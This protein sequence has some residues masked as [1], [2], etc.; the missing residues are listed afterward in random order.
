MKSNLLQKS[1][2]QMLNCSFDQRK[3]TQSSDLNNEQSRELFKTEIYRALEKYNNNKQE[4]SK[5]YK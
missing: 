3:Q 2:V 5:E 4:Q 1:T